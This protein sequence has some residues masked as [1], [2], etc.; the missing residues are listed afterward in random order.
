MDRAWREQY[1][2]GSFTF[3]KRGRGCPGNTYVGELLNSNIYGLYWNIRRKTSHRS[4]RG[5]S[6]TIYK[7]K[8]GVFSTPEIHDFQNNSFG[9]C[10]VFDN[11][12][13]A[14]TEA[15][16]YNIPEIFFEKFLEKYKEVEERLR[17][18]HDVE[19]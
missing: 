5:A 14:I 15:R 9:K 1:P 11:L 12:E 13:D 17:N 7:T 16:K 19:E 10:F 18:K 2:I 4:F 3:Q 8:L 6:T